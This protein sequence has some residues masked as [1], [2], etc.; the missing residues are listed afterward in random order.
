[1]PIF[2]NTQIKYNILAGLVG[3]VLFFSIF[4]LILQLNH[5]N[6]NICLDR[7][8]IDMSQAITD[9][10]FGKGCIFNLAMRTALKPNFKG[11]MWNTSVT[12]NSRGF[13]D[14]EGIFL[15]KKGNKDIRI[16][17]LGDSSTFGVK[18]NFDDAY[19]KVLERMLNDNIKEEKYE[20]LNGG[21]AG[22]TTFCGLKMFEEKK[23]LS[24]YPD[25]VTVYFGVNDEYLW[26]WSSDAACYQIRV[27]NKFFQKSRVF[28]LLWK[29]M[30]ERVFKGNIQL[31]SNM[32]KLT[33]RV[34]LS[35]FRSNLC[36][37]NKILKKHNIKGLFMTY[38]SKTELFPIDNLASA[39]RLKA[40]NETIR[41]MS[42]KHGFKM[43]D[44]EKIFIEK[45]DN[46]EKLFADYCHPS[47][48][49]HKIIAEEI[50]KKL[51]E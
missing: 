41:E 47:S 39:N 42:R 28:S 19:S 10:Y 15:A 30:T 27:L 5:F 49:G 18:V 45:Y 4:E 50:Y 51:F 1:M 34:S 20:I 40:Y 31:T 13:R 46:D 22:Y 37:I 2:Y 38:P 24:Y 8:S 48:Y 7:P 25:I 17:C 12:I 36:A 9:E 11:D 23:L 14:R 6:Y 26:H 43:L 16:I 21:C 32:G 3:T 33:A 44:L 29:V 35:E